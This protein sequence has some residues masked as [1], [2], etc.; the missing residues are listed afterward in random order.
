MRSTR[1]GACA[2]VVIFGV[3]LGSLAQS[4]E[5]KGKPADAGRPSQ[6]SFPAPQHAV[7][8]IHARQV[9]ASTPSAV[10]GA[11]ALNAIGNG[12]GK[13]LANG[14]GA[15]NAGAA[16]AGN[17]VGLGNN[18]PVKAP[19][20]ALAKKEAPAQKEPLDEARADDGKRY[21]LQAVLP[22]APGTFPSIQKEAPIPECFAR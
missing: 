20:I 5:G 8:V 22:V 9:V 12:L 18:F 19:A 15:G 17:A 6:V 2:G 13:G 14:N 4:P 10:V 3:A 1:F 11:P 16:G 21:S 7:G